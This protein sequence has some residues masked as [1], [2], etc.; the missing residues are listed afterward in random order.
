MHLLG[1]RGGSRDGEGVLLATES[2]RWRR[3]WWPV[4][5]LTT[6]E[7]GRSH[8]TKLLESLRTVG[9]ATSKPSRRATVVAA[10]WAEMGS[11]ISFA[12]LTPASSGPGAALDYHRAWRWEGAAGSAGRTE[13]TSEAPTTMAMASSSA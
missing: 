13:S 1:Q 7:A 11:V 2:S 3:W 8:T 5:T 12:G 9:L 4:A 10:S 6:T